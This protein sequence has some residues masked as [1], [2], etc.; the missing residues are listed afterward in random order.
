MNETVMTER[1]TI[2]VRITGRVQGVWYRGWTV[3]HARRLGLSGWVRN[4]R[5]GS[6]E[7]VFSGP[8][9][10]LRAMVELCRQGPP[11]ALVREVAEQIETAPL[12]PGFR[13]APTV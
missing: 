13:Q 12:E 9:P 4:R 7:A 5:D 10:A 2:R 3:D 8:E 11:A 1:V 6:V